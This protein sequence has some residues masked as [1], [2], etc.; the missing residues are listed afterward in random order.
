MLKTHH[1]SANLL[2]LLLVGKGAAQEVAARAVV[3]R[4]GESAPAG[5]SRGAESP[6]G[7]VAL[8]KGRG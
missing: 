2:I 6:L 3:A 5:A 1:K 4:A 8:P 7:E